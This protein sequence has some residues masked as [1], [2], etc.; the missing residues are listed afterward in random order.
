[1]R[2]YRDAGLRAS[3]AARGADRAAPC[4]AVGDTRE[5]ALERAAAAASAYAS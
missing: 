5:Q 2:I 1:V 3:A 4:I